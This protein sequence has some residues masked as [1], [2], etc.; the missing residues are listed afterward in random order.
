MSRRKDGPNA[1]DMPGMRCDLRDRRRGDPARW[2]P[3]RMLCLLACLARRTGGVRAR[4][5]ADPSAAP[6]SRSRT[7]ARAPPG[8]AAAGR[9]GKRKR[10][11]GVAGRGGARTGAAQGN[12]AAGPERPRHPARRASGAGGRAKASTGGRCDRGRPARRRSGT[13]RCGPCRS[14]ARQAARRRGVRCR[15]SP[16]APRGGSAG[17]RIGC[18]SAPQPDHPLGVRRFPVA[19]RDR[20]FR[21]F[22]ETMPL[23]RRCRPWR[24]R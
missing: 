9:C 2:P 15:R 7:R 13:T 8:H 5:G 20:L 10:P 23:P 16:A 24:P 11:A 18:A 4:G 19:L 21:L 17:S 14:T 6:C 12:S 3:C 22:L 1:A